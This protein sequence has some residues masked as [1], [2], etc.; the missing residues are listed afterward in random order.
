M[1]SRIIFWTGFGIATR[2]W[3]LGLQQIK[4]WSPKLLWAYPIFGACGA[5]FGYWLETVDKKQVEILQERKEAILAKRA[6]RA[7]REGE[8]A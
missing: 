1:V 4:P 8:A 2:V 3:Q 6:R 7:A 5:S